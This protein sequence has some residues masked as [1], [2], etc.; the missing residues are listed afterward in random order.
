M[1]RRD[2]DRRVFVLRRPARRLAAVLVGV[3]S[4]LVAPGAPPPVAASTAPPTTDR[5]VGFY[6]SIGPLPESTLSRVTHLIDFVTANLHDGCSPSA[7]DDAEFA[8]LAEFK[9]THPNLNVMLSIGLGGDQWSRAAASPRLTE[10]IASSCAALIDRLGFDGLDVDWEFPDGPTDKANLTPFMAGL[11]SALDALGTG[12]HFLS[13]DTPSAWVQAVPPW[14]DFAAVSQSVDWY[15]VMAYDSAGPLTAAEGVT[16]FNAPLS[17]PTGATFLL[18]KF[19]NIVV[20]REL[21]RQAGVPDHQ[22]VMGL[23]FYGVQYKHVRPRNNGIWQPFDRSQDDAYQQ[24]CYHD[25]GPA[26]A[27]STRTWNEGAASPWLWDEATSTAIS[28]DDPESISAKTTYVHNERLGGVMVFTLN[29][30]D[31]EGNLTAAVA[32]AMDAAIPA[33]PP[34]DATPALPAAVGPRFTG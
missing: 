25:L 19:P 20:S 31:P 27:S 26:L 24:H 17:V 33:A 12:H 10:R 16:G 14:I 4:V 7:E 23:P 6:V 29:C 15:N 18:A 2:E 13:M 8:Q 32:G 21:Y 5:I 11:R 22:I 34:P 9:A 1:Y 28:Y 3:A 30:D